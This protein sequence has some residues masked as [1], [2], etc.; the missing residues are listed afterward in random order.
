MTAKD[1][2]K[3]Y[4]AEKDQADA[5]QK[6]I[7]YLEDMKKRVKAV[8]YTGM[9]KAGNQG[10]LSDAEAYI[11]ELMDKY[12]S[13]ILS[14]IGK[15]ADILDRINRME[16]A[17]EREVLMWRYINNRDRDGRKLTWDDIAAK[18]PCSRRTAENYHGRALQNFPM[19]D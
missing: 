1:Y 5:C 11:D 8:R 14:Y 3:S 6:R 17:E 7:K 19:D 13:I 2:L 18:I 15:E 4:V 16:K 9:P 10:D 12:V